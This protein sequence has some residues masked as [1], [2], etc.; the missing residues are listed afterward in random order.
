MIVF[1]ALAVALIGFA[2]G[3]VAGTAYG[4]TR[5]SERFAEQMLAAER[6]RRNSWRSDW[7]R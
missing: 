7:G 3:F 4:V 2:V 1:V 6:R 5:E